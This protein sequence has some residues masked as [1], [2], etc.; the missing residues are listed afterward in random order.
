[1]SKHK[2]HARG[3]DG[4][5]VAIALQQRFERSYKIQK[6]GCWEWTANKTRKGY[7]WIYSDGSKLTAHRLSYEIHVGP[8]PEGMQIDH[9]CRNRGCVNPAH[10]E[11]VTGLEN[12]RRGE[13]FSARQ[14][15]QTHCKRG[16]P[17]SGPNLRIR[18]DG[19]RI[20][21]ECKRLIDARY[22]LG[23]SRKEIA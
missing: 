16:H 22:K 5:F 11:A 3:S 1:M 8:I 6:N 7:G 13:S 21:K 2:E 23:K 15:R 20:C 14:R 18:N 4:K 12:V 19:S 10:L 17:L 9:L